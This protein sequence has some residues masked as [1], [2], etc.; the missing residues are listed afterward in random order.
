MPRADSVGGGGG[1]NSP[2][3]PPWEKRLEELLLAEALLL[4]DLIYIRY[5]INKLA[6]LF[7]K[8]QNDGL[9]PGQLQG[10]AESR[11]LKFSH[12]KTLYELA[13]RVKNHGKG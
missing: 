10:I 8:S 4:A 6:G 2:P 5:A 13:E 12:K 3:L 1:G 7:E 11:A 9:L